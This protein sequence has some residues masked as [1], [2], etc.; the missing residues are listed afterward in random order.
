[1]NNAV[2]CV[3]HSHIVDQLSGIVMEKVRPG[4]NQYTSIVVLF[5]SNYTLRTP[6]GLCIYLSFL[7][8]LEYTFKVVH[9]LMPNL[10]KNPYKIV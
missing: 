6:L 1:M 5:P 3:G 4:S 7:Q 10:I 8:L 2:W 9:Y